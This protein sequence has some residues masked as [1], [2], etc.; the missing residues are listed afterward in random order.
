[1][2]SQGWGSRASPLGPTDATHGGSALSITQSLHNRTGKTAKPLLERQVILREGYFPDLY[3]QTKAGS[4]RTASKSAALFIMILLSQHQSAKLVYDM[5]GKV[6]HYEGQ[7]LRRA[8]VPL[9]TC[10]GKL[11][12]DFRGN[13]MSK[14]FN[15]TKARSFTWKSQGCWLLGCQLLFSLSAIQL[16]AAFKI[17]VW[18]FYVVYQQNIW[19]CGSRIRD[20]NEPNMTSETAQWK[21]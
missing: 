20:F 19:W 2:E 1:M 11:P 14:A 12:A 18:I 4:S 3:F 16:T 21:W 5:C 17:L 7:H 10:L 15:H 8:V 13:G 6:L 9:Q